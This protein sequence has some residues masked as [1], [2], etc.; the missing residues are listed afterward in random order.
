MPKHIDIPQ[1]S[2]WRNLEVSAARY[3]HKPAIVFYDS[4]LTYADLE[5]DAQ[6]LA[7][8]LQQRC[9]VRRGDRVALF[10][11]N[12]PQFIVG[13]YAILRADAM[14]VPVNSMSTAAE[15]SHIIADCD[16]QTLITA[17]DLL[18][19]VQPCAGLLKHTVVACYSDYLTTATDLTLP[20]F[21]RS[22][23]RA[24]EDTTAVSWLEALAQQ[25]VPAAHLANAE[26][27]CVMPYTSGTTGKPKGCIHRHRN[28]MHTA[29]A[30]ARWHGKH[31]EERVL[32]VLPFFHVT[33][34]QTGMNM[35]LF[36]GATL[37]VMSRWDREV[38]AKL[39]QRHRVTGW[40]TVPTIVVDLLSSA[41]LQGGELASLLSIGGGGAAMPRAV[42]E[43]LQAYCSLTYIEGY[44]LSE[45]MAP[46][47]INPT[48]RPKT[49]CLGLPIFD[50]DSRIVDPQTL[51]PLPPGEVGEIVIRGPQVFEGYWHD[52]NGS[53]ASFIDLEDGRYFRSG[54]LGYVD[55][56][57]YFFFV[58][59]L[60]RM[61]NAAGFKVW[62]AEVEAQ[63]Y[64][65]PAIQEVV[66][67]ATPEPRR[68]E[69]V[70][71]IIVLRPEARGQVTDQQLIE[72][73]RSNM[74]AYK[75]PRHWAFVDSLPK[76]A[77]GK[78]QWRLL[79]EQEFQAAAAAAVASAAATPNSTHV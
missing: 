5:R 1:T 31:T 40:T 55:D 39:I 53:A 71:A 32:C 10:L 16:A 48:E 76:S 61:I 58:D 27:L 28:V 43:K 74:A 77:S 46:S 72:W 68:G 38:A 63:L 70:K 34:M 30:L 67:I 37:I 66:I 69:A 15:L 41:N 17:H 47:H 56:E 54:D 75:I 60:K 29:V 3:P 26:D 45:T 35:P 18:Q 22:P 6:H 7:G 8:F 73:A 13:Y 4:I 57:G 19:H 11:H 20:D 49:Q 50:T 9:G 24:I 78:I 65:H 51:Q 52:P 36:L 62:P 42:A 33:G 14:V 21:I 59:R 23:R 12:S 79:Q 2:L 64:A 44:G 25:L